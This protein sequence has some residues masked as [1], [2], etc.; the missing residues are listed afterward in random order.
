MNAMIYTRKRREVC[1]NCANISNS[2]K[3]EHYTGNN[4][5]TGGDIDIRNVQRIAN[6]A[7]SSFNTV[8]NA[9]LQISE[10]L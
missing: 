4:L 8:G 3:A 7:K 2:D 1:V 6:K 9:S 5:A 10:A